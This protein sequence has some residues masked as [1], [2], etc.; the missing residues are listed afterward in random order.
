MSQSKFY[1]YLSDFL[2]L[3]QYLY[4]NSTSSFLQSNYWITTLDN[5]KQIIMD[6]CN[7][8]SNMSNELCSGLFSALYFFI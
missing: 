2:Y 5:I 7:F 3:Q 6:Y 1:N 8:T 4:N